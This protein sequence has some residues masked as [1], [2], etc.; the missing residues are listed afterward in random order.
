M[1]ERD[2]ERLE[3][4]GTPKHTTCFL[5]REVGEHTGEMR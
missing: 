2:S 1:S 5:L 3:W 4:I